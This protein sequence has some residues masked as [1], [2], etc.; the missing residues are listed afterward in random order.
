MSTNKQ[1]GLA[2]YF[3]APK[4]ELSVGCACWCLTSQ[5]NVIAA[6]TRAN[7]AA[8]R[9]PRRSHGEDRASS[10]GRIMDLL[11]TSESFCEPCSQLSL[12]KKLRKPFEK[13]TA[14]TPHEIESR[15][16][17]MKKLIAATILSVYSRFAAVL[18]KRGIMGKRLSV[19]KRNRSPPPSSCS[20]WNI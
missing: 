15:G 16:L 5:A 20:T 17:G 14:G 2:T 11:K 6:S 19:L 8:T 3:I 10:V 1:G 13:P 9:E 18:L 12:N 7:V 4:T